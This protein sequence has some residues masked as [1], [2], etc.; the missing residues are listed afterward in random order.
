MLQII[1]AMMLFFVMM[2]GIGFILNMLMKTTWFPIYLYLIVLLPLGIYY[3]WDDSMNFAQNMGA[4]TIVDYLPAIT[5]LAGAYISGTAI[6]SLR[7][8][9]YKMF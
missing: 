4:Y 3:T 9:G 2:F 1:V 6:R 8:G 7:R 5:A